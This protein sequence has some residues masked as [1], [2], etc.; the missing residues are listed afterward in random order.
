M[1]KAKATAS[2]KCKACGFSQCVCVAVEDHDL[3]TPSGPPA[4]AAGDVILYK[5]SGDDAQHYARERIGRDLTSDEML[6][7]KKYVEYG[8]NEC[9]TE[10]VDIAVELTIEELGLS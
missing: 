3:A 4:P 1:A 10:V 7:V 2:A 9:W 5:L 6:R 8:M